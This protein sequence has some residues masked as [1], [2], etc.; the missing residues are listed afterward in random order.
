[1]SS[2]PDHCEVYS[3]HTLCDK[4][5]QW[6]ATGRRFSPSTPVPLTNKTY[7][8]DK[9][10][11]LLIVALNTITLTHMYKPF[12]YMFVCLMVFNATL[13]NISVISWWSVLLV[14]GTRVPGDNH[15]PAASP[16]QTLSHNVVNL[17]LIEIRTHTQLPYDHGHDG[18]FSHI[19]MIR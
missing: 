16:W 3:I 11:I 10:D 19:N 6:L 12:P 13:N 18:P 4:V 15:Q 1:M 17:S 5:C 14:E 9:N 2:H 8:H 7:R